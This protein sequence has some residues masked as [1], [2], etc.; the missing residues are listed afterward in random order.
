MTHIKL[1]EDVIQTYFDGMY[2]SNAQ[3]THLAF[4]ANAK[5]LAI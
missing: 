1:I 2:Q 4:H 3:K 5:L